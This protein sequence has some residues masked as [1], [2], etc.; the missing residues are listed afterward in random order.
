MTQLGYQD[1]TGLWQTAGGDPG[2]APFM[3]AV[4]YGES[5]WNSTAWNPDASTLDNS[6]G[7]WQINYFGSLAPSRTARYGAPAVLATDPLAQA[8]AAVDIFGDNGAGIGAWANN[9][10]VKIWKSAGAPQKPDA[11]TVA[12]YIRK[13]AEERKSGDPF[14]IVGGLSTSNVYGPMG[15]QGGRDITGPQGPQGGNVQGPGIG[16]QYGS[17][18]AKLSL[19]VVGTVAKGIG[20]ACQVKALSSGLLIGL[21]GSMLIAGAVLLVAALAAGTKAGQTAAGI[22]GTALGGPGAGRLASSAA[23]ALGGLGRS[24]AGS[25]AIEGARSGARRASQE[26][27]DRE[28]EALFNEVLASVA[29]SRRNPS[30]ARRRYER[31]RPAMRRASERT[32]PAGEQ[33]F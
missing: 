24:S 2:W 7:L 17:D 31:Q 12:G 5:N 20:N 4:A 30:E 13:V 19:P 21:G 22:A 33:P 14:A 6:V 18:G 15:P 16:C 25:R 1:V 9:P 28:Q 32:A 26:K 29:E 3:A 10:V 11:E 23:G 8:R 27:A